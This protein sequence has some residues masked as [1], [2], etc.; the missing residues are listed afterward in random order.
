MFVEAYLEPVMDSWYFSQNLKDPDWSRYLL[1]LL[2]CRHG[3]EEFNLYVIFLKCV[4]C[5]ARLSLCVSVG[6]M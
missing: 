6:G 2:C 3:F 1:E 4:N 5:N